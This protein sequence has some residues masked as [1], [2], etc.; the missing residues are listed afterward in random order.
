MTV[1][2][3]VNGESYALSNTSGALIHPMTKSA[4]TVTFGSQKG[5]E[6]VDILSETFPSGQAVTFDELGAPDSPGSVTVAC[7]AHS[8]RIDVAAATG[9]VTATS[10]GL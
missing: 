6:N 10:T 4:Y 5:F 3:D 2:F 9:K 7:G 8:Y 1:T